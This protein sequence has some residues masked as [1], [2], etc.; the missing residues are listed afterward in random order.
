MVVPLR[1]TMMLVPD[2]TA[3]RVSPATNVTAAPV[4]MA[5]FVPPTLL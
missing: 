3:L 2:R 1:L 5:V 4:A